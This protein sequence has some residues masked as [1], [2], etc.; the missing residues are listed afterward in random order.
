MCIGIIRNNSLVGGRAQAEAQTS[1]TDTR[2]ALL[3]MAAECADHSATWAGPVEGQFGREFPAICNHCVV[4][5]AW[6]RE[7]WK[8]CEQFLSFLN[9]PLW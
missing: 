9:D 3:H 2:H 7:T 1:A 6:S 5:S 8:F 4:M